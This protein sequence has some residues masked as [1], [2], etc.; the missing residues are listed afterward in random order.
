MVNS[1]SG[2]PLRSQQASYSRALF[3][4]PIVMGC[5]APVLS[6]FR[7]AVDMII[8]VKWAAINLGGEGSEYFFLNGFV[9]EECRLWSEC[10][11]NVQISNDQE[12]LSK[13]DEM[14]PILDAQTCR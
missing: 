5:A 4:F 12:Y 8:K 3:D 10:R 9:S 7:L 1:W 11:W 14:S 6:F 2:D 13:R